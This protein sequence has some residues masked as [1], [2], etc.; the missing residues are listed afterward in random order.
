MSME[1]YLVKTI[2]HKGYV[3]GIYQD[4]EPQN[5][6]D[7]DNLG[8]MACWNRRYE[9]GDIRPEEIPQEFINA[10]PKG[11]LLL[12]LYLY[13]HSGITMNTS[14]FSHIDYGG[15]DSGQ[16]GVIYALPEKVC[17]EYGKRITTGIKKR[18]IACL[19]SEVKTYDQFLRGD[20]Y[21][22]RV[23]YHDEEIDSCWGFFGVDDCAADARNVADGDE[24]RHYKAAMETQANAE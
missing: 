7:W 9:L 4:P 14:G 22:F 15:W 6:R 10:L 2:Y 16:V 24:A 13:D 12:P 1:D 21:G 19:E 5:P 20:I 11:T 8:V 17:E 23:S 18:V 3:I